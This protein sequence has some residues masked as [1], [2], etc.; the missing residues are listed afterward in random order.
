MCRSGLMQTAATQAMSPRSR[1]Q[2]ALDCWTCC[3]GASA[4][5]AMVQSAHPSVRVRLTYG[6]AWHAEQDDKLFAHVIEHG[7]AHPH[8]LPWARARGRLPAAAGC[9]GCASRIVLPPTVMSHPPEELDMLLDAATHTACPRRALPPLPAPRARRR[10][11]QQQQLRAL[12]R[13]RTSARGRRHPPALW[14]LG[15]S[16]RGLRLARSA[17]ALVFGGDEREAQRARG[18]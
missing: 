15:C 10:R 14:L 12:R 1:A 11:V 7:Q 2:R 9:L 5:G 16:R 17:R 6:T 8:V 4:G 3:A 18:R 13:A